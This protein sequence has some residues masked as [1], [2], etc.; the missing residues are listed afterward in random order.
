MIFVGFH[1]YLL[2]G[3]K[4]CKMSFAENWSKIFY[5]EYDCFYINRP[6]H[7]SWVDYKDIIL[8]IIASSSMK[9]Y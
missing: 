7:S 9:S 6:R 2:N 8:N 5:L 4:L 3:Q 1:V